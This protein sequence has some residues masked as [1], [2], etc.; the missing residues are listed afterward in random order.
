MLNWDEYGKEE[1]ITPP[2]AASTEAVK[3]TPEPQEKKT[4]ASY[5]GYS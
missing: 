3:V 5:Y 4:R 2:A 1:N